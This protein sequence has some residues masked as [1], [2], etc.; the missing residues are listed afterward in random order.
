MKSNDGDLVV[1]SDQ[2]IDLERYA[3]V[4]AHTLHFRSAPTGEVLARLNMPEK[5]W[6]EAHA[7]WTQVL[8]D[9]A[10]EDKAPVA[11]RFG[12]AF[13]TTRARLRAEQPTL[14]SLGSLPVVDPPTPDPVFVELEPVP[15]APSP[16]LAAMAPSRPPA[17]EVEAAVPS[18]ML[19]PSPPTPAPLA[20]AFALSSPP[21]SAL[22][23]P[24]RVPAARHGDLGATANS[25][26][27]PVRPAMPFNLGGT[28]EQSLADV[29]ARMT[30]AQGAPSVDGA[31]PP[32]AQL[33]ETVGLVSTPPG[34]ALPFGTNPAVPPALSWM[35]AGMLKLTSVDGTQ[36]STDTPT[37]PVLPFEPAKRSPS[38]LE[39][40]LAQ[41]AQHQGT[42]PQPTRDPGLAATMEPGNPLDFRKPELPFASAVAPIPARTPAHSIERYASICVELSAPSANRL[43]TLRRYQLTESEWITLDAEWKARLS[44]EPGARAAWENACSAYRAWLAQ[45]SQGKG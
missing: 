12:A 35:P 31:S 15:L 36:L 7:K 16:P 28:P 26:N 19:V 8:I 4:L 5:R 32:R 24:P 25:S 40:V 27:L 11:R 21:P 29:I 30:A 1:V 34:N 44:R 45:A 41:A 14:E 43:H 38:A 33:G 2:A 9:E 18:Y 20:P 3:E 13:A 17:V 23:Q 37:G 6:N 42:A 22:P 10:A 39:H